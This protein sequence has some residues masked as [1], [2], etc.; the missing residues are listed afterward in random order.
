VDD[1]NYTAVSFTNVSSE[2]F[3]WEWGSKPYTI[4]AGETKF[5]PEFLARHLA[6]HLI[7]RILGEHLGDKAQRAVW[8]AK[9]LCPAEVEV[10]SEKPLEAVKKAEEEVEPFADLKEK[11]KVEPR[12]KRI[13]RRK[14]I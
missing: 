3:T 14:K 5:Y 10:E 13:Q 2:S 8:E 12:R 1:L 9:I 11:V 7:N 4:A 6:K